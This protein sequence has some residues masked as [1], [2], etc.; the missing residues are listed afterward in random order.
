MK[1]SE[2][3]QDYFSRVI[4]VVNQMQTYGEEITDDWG[5]RDWVC[6][7]VSVCQGHQSSL[8]QGLILNSN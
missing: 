7:A 2:K 8:C 6:C 3:I 4:E 5:M 1:A